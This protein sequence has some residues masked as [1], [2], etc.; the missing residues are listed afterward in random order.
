MLPVLLRSLRRQ[1]W[2][3]GKELGCDCSGKTCFKCKRAAGECSCSH[4]ANASDNDTDK[5]RVVSTVE[6]LD[7]QMAKVP[8]QHCPVCDVG[9]SETPGCV[10]I[11]CL[12]GKYFEWSSGK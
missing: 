11:L 10:S 1:P 5:V 4:S 7:S 8:L 2:V 3:A 6:E 9:A 12:C